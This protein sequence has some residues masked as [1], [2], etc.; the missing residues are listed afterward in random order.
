MVKI[1]RDLVELYAKRE[2][3]EGFAFPPDGKMQKE[4]EDAFEYDP[5]PD[6][7]KATADIK[8][9]MESRRPMD[10]LICGDVGF[11]KTEVAMRAA[12]KCVVDKKQVVLLVP[13]TILAAQ[14]YENFMDRFAGFGVNIAL[15]NRYKSAKEKKEIFKQVSEG[16]VDIRC[17]YACLLSEKN[18]FKDLGLL[19][20]DEEQKFGVKQK[21]KLR[22]LRLA[23][24]TLSM[25]ATPIPRS[26]HL[27]MTGVRDISLINTPPINR[28]PVETK[29]MKRDD[30]VLKQAI[31][32]E[33]ARGGQVFVVNDRVQ[34]IYMLAEDVESWVPEARVA[35]AHGQMKDRDLERVMDAFLSRKVRYSREH[36]HYRIGLGCSECEY[37]YHHERASLWH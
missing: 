36:E 24:D 22:E 23:V 37:D 25:S 20:I 26:L 15:V 16:K 34:N 4:F 10:R 28:L 35:V 14:H 30:M 21:E 19:I 7:V 31:E 3:V 33:L 17:R 12:F 1:A 13:T 5:T 9:D 18:Q 27:S 32:D 6:Q 11:G 29:L 8:R 2:L